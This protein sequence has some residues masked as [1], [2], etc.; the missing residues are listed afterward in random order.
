[1]LGT[2]KDSNNGRLQPVMIKYYFDNTPK[3]QRVTSLEYT[4]GT[5]AE[6]YVDMGFLK[7]TGTT[8]TYALLR[9]AIEQSS[10]H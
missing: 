6:A 2:R 10:S 7:D 3:A 8:P 9:C 4:G 1:M 5:S